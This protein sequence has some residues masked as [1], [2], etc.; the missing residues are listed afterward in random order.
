MSPENCITHWL[1]KL[2]AA[3]I[4][5]P[6]TQIV[7]MPDDYSGV[8]DIMD[9]KDAPPWVDGFANEL[10]AAAE[11]VGGAPVFLR[12]GHFSG[13]H[14]WKKTCHVK[15]IRPVSMWTHV[16]AIIELGECMSI[17]GFPWGVWAV[18]EYLQPSVSDVAFLARSFGDMPVRREFRAFV[19]G[20]AVRCVHPY[21]PPDALKQDM[22]GGRDAQLSLINTIGRDADIINDTASRAGAALGGA[23]SVDLLS[24]NGGWYV[25]DCAVAG[26]SYHW[27][28]CQ[29]LKS[30]AT[31]GAGGEGVGNV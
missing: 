17:I 11:L 27:P 31:A 21:W 10:A 28:D 1:P 4:R 29:T 12:S 5:T 22:G 3:G 7:R 8:F 30:P 25:T 9:G 24:T 18:R 19:D 15:D 20:P 23:W 13:K 16:L 26:E 2:E 14:D 6:R